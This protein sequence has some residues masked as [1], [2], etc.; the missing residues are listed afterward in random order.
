MVSRAFGQAFPQ[1]SNRVGCQQGIKGTPDE[2]S[3]H[4]LQ[5]LLAVGAHMDNRQVRS[6]NGQQHPMGL[7]GA[8]DMNRFACRRTTDRGGSPIWM[9]LPPCRAS[10][11]AWEDARDHKHDGPVSISQYCPSNSPA[12]QSQ[13]DSRSFVKAARLT[14]TSSE[15]VEEPQPSDAPPMRKVGI[16]QRGE[17]ATKHA[18]SPRRGDALSAV[19]RVVPAFV[20]D[21]RRRPLEEARKAAGV[22][23]VHP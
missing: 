6:I 15:G 4:L 21:R 1:Q 22:R 12:A 14:E 20:T 18:A 16:Q 7:N 17:A 2:L 23:A 9:M 10:T 19:V 13:S 3:G 5:P 11:N 8:G